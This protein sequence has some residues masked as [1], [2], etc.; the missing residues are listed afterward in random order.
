MSATDMDP[1]KID[2]I[3]YKKQILYP[4]APHRS[5]HLGFPQQNPFFTVIP[6]NTTQERSA[7]PEL[8]EVEI[9][10]LSI[11]PIVTG[12]EIIDVFVRTPSLRHP[13]P[14][15]ISSELTGESILE[16]TR[17]GKYLLFRCSSGCILVHLGM[18][19]H[20]N[21][22]PSST[23][24]SR[25]DHL[26]FVLSGDIYLRYTDPRRFGLILWTR[27]PP[28]KHPLLCNLGPEPLAPDFSAGDL[29][30]RSNNR[31]ISIK[32]FL[33]DNRVIVG[34]GNIYTN[35]ALFLAGISPL[36]PAKGLSEQEYER[37]LS[38]IRSALREAI[39][40]GMTHLLSF[41]AAEKTAG[42]FPLQFRVYGRAGKP[43]HIC[44][45]PINRVRQ[46]QRSTYFCTLCQR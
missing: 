16:I 44:G 42:Y 41:H 40:A 15:E 46:G 7:V 33:M 19:G 28:L 14:E 36:R 9:T 5:I 31:T 4:A 32:Q 17:R 13:I 18:S 11:A 35:E 25:H 29:I 30:T 8:P 26:D 3:V 43:C 6:S 21:V 45:S 1:P 34:L 12:R 2:F 38:A 20:L 23:R 22:V 24:P 27:T 39:S 37:L 10:R